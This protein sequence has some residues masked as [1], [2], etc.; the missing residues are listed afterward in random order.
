MGTYIKPIVFYLFH[1]HLHILDLSAFGAQKRDARWG[2]FNLVVTHLPD[3]ISPARL[4]II[5]P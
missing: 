4:A 2:A 3:E 5:A 1:C